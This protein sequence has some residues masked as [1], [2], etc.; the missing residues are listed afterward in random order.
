M[1]KFNRFWNKLRHFILPTTRFLLLI[2]FSCT[3]V[4]TFFLA[5]ST[6]QLTQQPQSSADIGWEFEGSQEL[7]K[8]SIQE[9][10]YEGECPGKDSRSIKAW[11][12]SSKTPPAPKRR[13]IVKNV[14]RGLESNPYPYTDREYQK[15]KSSE[16][17][18][19][20]FGT[21]HRGSNF[22]VMESENEFQYEIKENKTVIDSG[23]FI[24]VIDKELDVRRRDATVTKNS[25]CFNSAVDLNV[26]ADI[27]NKTEYTCPNNKIL[28]SIVEPN[29][30]EITT[31]ISNQMFGD[32]VYVLNGNIYTLRPGEEKRY[33]AGSLSIQ[34]NSTCPVGCKP[35]TPPQSLQPGKRYQFKSSSGFIQ[36]V[37]FPK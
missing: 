17:T 37:D 24:A 27:R 20:I 11:F 34:F 14:T 29:N 23:S 15:G 31:I 25:V 35:K 21:S 5:S 10:E 8:G 12:T 28:R 19:I 9:I 6:A 4:V 30:P 16:S 3:L 33:T 22:I 32:V 26:C 7:N 13:V 2:A 1:K 36:L 18:Q